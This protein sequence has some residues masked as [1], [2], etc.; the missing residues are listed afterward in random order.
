MEIFIPTITKALVKG[1]RSVS[2]V[3]SCL[4]TALLALLLSASAAYGGAVSCTNTSADAALIQT[5]INAG[6][7]LSLSGVCALGPTVINIGKSITITGSAQINSTANAAFMIWGNGVSIN[8]LTFNGS[9]VHLI[10]T[11]QQSGFT[12]TNN[13]VQNTNGNDGITV[14]AI[15]RSSNISGNSFF[16][17]A[18]NG[19]VS[20]TFASLGFGACYQ[21]GN[22]DSRGV[23]IYI[24]GGLDQTTINNNSF[25]LIASDGMHIGWNIIGADAFYFLTKNNDISYNKF[26]RVHRI[27]I[28]AQA[29]FSSPHCGVG[30]AYACDFSHDFS[31]NTTIKGN[32][33]HDPFLTYIE[34]FAYS[35]ALWGSGQYINNAG[36]ANITTGQTPGYGIEDMGNNVLTQGNVMAADYITNANPHGWAGGIVYGSEAVGAVFTSQNNVLCGDKATSLNFILEPPYSSGQRVTLYNYISNT[37]PN[38]GHLT[39]SAIS[40]AFVSPTNSAINGTWNVTATSTLP[41]KYVQFFLDGSATPAVTQELQ[42]VST[43]FAIDQKWLYHAALGSSLGAGTHTIVAKATDLAGVTSSVTQSFSGGSATSPKLVLTPGNLAFGVQTLGL[44]TPALTAKLTN[45]GTAPL[46]I[47]AINSSGANSKDFVSTSSCAALLPVGASCNIS[48]VFKPSVTGVA[49]AS[50]S[51]ANNASGSPNTITLSG[52]GVAPTGSTP[53]PA[54]PP[55]PPTNP[56][57]VGS[58]PTNLPKG[59]ILWLAND[60]GVVATGTAVSAWE[61]QSGSGNN[62]TQSSAA[63]QPA[64]VAG[65][66]GQKALL[67]DGK[68][69]FL[70]VPSLSITGLSGMTVFLVSSNSLNESGAGY[71]KYAFLS[72]P[73][74]I[75]WGGTFFGTYQTSSHFRFGTTESSNEN[76]YQLPLN[77]GN[78]FGLSEW[79]HNGTTD[80]MWFN[81]Q[82]AG[83]YSGKWAAIN[84]TGSSA[85]IG[86]GDQNTYYPGEASEVI[87]YNRALTTAERQLVE[88]YLMQKYHL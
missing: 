20:S 7:N 28:E 33:F 53:P 4:P 70:S 39:T 56:P 61:D 72:W 49:T 12:F 32:Y 88:Q 29:V 30:G 25:D 81:T 16:N 67:F 83:S 36:I 11:P 86:R 6:S 41:L 34:T 15:L 60:A 43:T 63:N 71:A 18:P 48:A 79:M 17:I 26:T 80:S 64:L 10:A 75:S 59:M 5:A 9:G 77:V 14:D 85:T 65:N 22:C 68:A 38:A 47:S 23:G 58:L 73:E 76:T 21:K 27:G 46:T 54:P 8:G 42:D 82:G 24:Y 50:L 78:S 57:T 40:L 44:T 51:I 52:T 31:A 35:L 19:F 1:V 37:C 66:N 74:T 62:A 45:G 3:K 84:G 2:F 13:R 69:S 87:I 55:T